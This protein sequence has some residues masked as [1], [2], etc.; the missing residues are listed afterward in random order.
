MSCTKTIPSRAISSENIK[1]MVLKDLKAVIVENVGDIETP[2]EKV[3]VPDNGIMKITTEETGRVML[4]GIYVNAL[5]IRISSRNKI[6]YLNNRPFRGKLE[7][8]H[9]EKGLMVINDVDIEMYLV[10]L[11]NHEISSK[12]HIEAVKA[13]AVIARTYALYQKTKKTNAPYHLEGTVLGQVY[14][15]RI[16][17]D[18]SAFEAVM[19]TTGMVLK[20][21]G[22][23]ALAVYHSN[24][25][26]WTEA[27]QN[28]WA[29]EYPYLKTV[30][31]PYDE[32]APNFEWNLS[33]TPNDI[34]TAL[35]NAG[36]KVGEVEA[37]LPVEKTPT[38]RIKKIRIIH[39]NGKLEIAGEDLRRVLGY[40]KL[41]STRF[42]IKPVAEDGKVRLFDFSGKGSG[43]GVGLSQWGA[44]GMAEK[45]YT[46]KDI[47]RHYYK[48]VE[49][50]KI[51]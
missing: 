46:Y 50:E 25:G 43:H 4:N 19:E 34:S 42:E 20:Y 26:G 23:L 28:V 14:S 10:G 8:T 5:P 48:G 37:L 12:W 33:N 1:I 31:S 3:D 40:D 32:L 30:E 27:S 38:S 13:Q 2:S 22:D 15:G 45:G 16:T 41:K 18:E 51:Y 44:K 49:I 29:R 21:N 36:Y 39:K 11:I 6:L 17:E 7:V 9:G 24:A 47:L 35:N